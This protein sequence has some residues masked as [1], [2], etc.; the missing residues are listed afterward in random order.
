MTGKGLKETEGE[1]KGRNLAP[2]T[3]I[4]PPCDPWKPLVS[5]NLTLIFFLR[6]CDKLREGMI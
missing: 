4:H 3:G 6:N 1:L 5:S 2:R